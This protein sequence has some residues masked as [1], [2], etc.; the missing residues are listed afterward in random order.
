[1]A[2][3]HNVVNTVFE[4]G[5]VG[6]VAVS[7]W[8]MAYVAGETGTATLGV[9]VITALVLLRQARVWR[10]LVTPEPVASQP[11]AAPVA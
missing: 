6:V 7:G 2:I 1:V 11:V 8:N 10:R 3:A 9:C 5:A 4:L